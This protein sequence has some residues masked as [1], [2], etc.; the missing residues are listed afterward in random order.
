M[1]HQNLIFVAWFAAAVA[2]FLGGLW[3][4]HTTATSYHFANGGQVTLGC[5]Q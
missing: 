3:A 5:K 1:K 2:V 4:G